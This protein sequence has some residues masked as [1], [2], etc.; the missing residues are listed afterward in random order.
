MTLHALAVALFATLGVYNF[1][2]YRAWHR[3]LVR[4]AQHHDLPRRRKLAS[5]HYPVVVLLYV[6]PLLWLVTWVF[7]AHRGELERWFVGALLVASIGPALVWW[8]HRWPSLKA[9]GYGRPR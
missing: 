3:H 4:L 8:F 9:L 6:V 1:L 2:L 5:Y 7:T